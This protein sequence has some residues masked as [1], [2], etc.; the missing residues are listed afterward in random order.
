MAGLVNNHHQRCVA[1]VQVRR[2]NTPRPST[3]HCQAAARLAP[4][5]MRRHPRTCREQRGRLRPRP[6]AA[7]SAAAVSLFIQPQRQ[8]PQKQC[9]TH[10]TVVLQLFLCVSPV[11]PL[12]A[13]CCML[14][15]KIVTGCPHQNVE[16]EAGTATRCDRSYVCTHTVVLLDKCVYSGHVALCQ[17]MY[18]GMTYSTVVLRLFL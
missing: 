6:A 4:R 3:R 18:R 1:M 8:P 14:L 11:R 9:P 16:T 5:W 15:H 13:P 12:S 10:T 7:A 2:A 17:Q